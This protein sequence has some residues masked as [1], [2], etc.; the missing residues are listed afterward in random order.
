MLMWTEAGLA[1]VLVVMAFVCPR[2]GGSWFDSVERRFIALANRRRLSIIV[3]A[4]AA[5]ALRAAALPVLPEPQPYVN[6]EFS[7]LLAADTFAHGRLANPTHPMWI[8]FETFHVIQQPTYASLYPP[9]QGLV[10]AFGQV[11]T[12]HPFV[13]VWLSVALMCAALCW[14]LQGWISP[15]W[16]LLGGL[17]SVMHFGV[18]SYWANSYWGG[19]VAATGGAL[20]LGA[21]PRIRRSQRVDDALLMGLGAAILANSRPYE[22]MILCLPVAVALIVWVVRGPRPPLRVVARRVVAPLR[23]SLT[24]AKTGSFVWWNLTETRRSGGPTRGKPESSSSRAR[25][26]AVAEVG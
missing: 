2:L 8:H 14:M 24:A 19:A 9:A 23:S 13:G 1:L 26:E 6:D 17:L 10:L 12:G 25:Y 15:P 22:G 16:A 18:F 7:F 5:L 21:L 3:V 4:L 11:T 20:V